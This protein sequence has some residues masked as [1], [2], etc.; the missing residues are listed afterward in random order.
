[1]NHRESR[2][3]EKYTVE[4]KAITVQLPAEDKINEKY[5]QGLGKQLGIDDKFI[6]HNVKK[7][8]FKISYKNMMLK[9]I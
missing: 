2:H 6:R 7:G 9:L 5:A 1:M 3:P 4:T 8:I